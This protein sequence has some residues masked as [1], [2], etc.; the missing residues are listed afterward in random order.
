MNEVTP[1]THPDWIWP[2][3]DSHI[4]LAAG[5]QGELGS[6]DVLKTFVEP[7]GSFSPGFG[8]YGVSLW[9]WL[10]AERL[11]VAP[12]LLPR[13]EIRDR[14][15]GGMLP[16]VRSRWRAGE[17]EVDLRLATDSLGS[18]HQLIDT[19][20]A[21]ITNRGQQP[22][23]AKVLLVVRSLGPAGGPVRD[24]AVD[25]D[26][27]GLLVNG[28]L[29]VMGNQAPDDAGCC[30]LAQD[31]RDV[32]VML[33]GGAMPNRVAAHDD[34][35][36]ASAAL[37][38]SI[39]LEPGGVWEGGW[40]CPVWPA[41]AEPPA[42]LSARCQWPAAARIE[43]LADAW[44]DCVA[45]VW[46][47]C[48]DVR[49]SE[50][51]C[52]AVSHTLM[53]WADDEA[54]I[55]S[56][57]Y[58]FFW[59]RD[60]V[61]L[62]NLLD[63]A[64]HHEL[65]RRALDALVDDP[66]AGGFG[67]EADGPAQLLWVIGEHY[68]FTRDA[69]W[70]RSVYPRVRERAE[71]LRAM[72]STTEPMHGPLRRVLP[73]TRRSPEGTLL[74]E[75]A[76]H[77]LIWGR[78]DWHRPIFWVNAWARIGLKHAAFLASEL[79]CVDDA[80]LWAAEVQALARALASPAASFGGNERDF[81]CAIWPCDARHADDLATREEFERRWNTLR[82]G[83][84]RVYHGEP[85]W[86]YFEAAEAHN[87]LRLGH[88]DRALLVLEQFLRTQD[89]PG[90]YGWAEGDDTGDPTGDWKDIRG[91]WP[92]RRRDLRRGSAIMPHGWISAELALL[93][94]DLLV[95][96]DDGQLVIGAGVRPEWIDPASGLAAEGA[97]LGITEI[98]RAHV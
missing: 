15:L 80:A 78:M 69:D 10:E 82:L 88:A 17:A 31:G 21:R 92:A 44:R 1:Q 71:L 74:C 27:H 50:L 43:G 67:P 6:P 94:R 34:A 25:P 75:P 55:A 72:R 87:L 14:L 35:G 77:G 28:R 59:T 41:W 60:G 32:S 68:L 42:A 38:Y 7:G 48:P 98:G 56:V 83:R 47:Q 5:A 23:S 58:P 61:Y 86:R 54:R 2:R 16:I 93:V 53:A 22:L 26:V 18:A 91:W 9:L 66:W 45:A 89:A 64:G 57:C 40:D 63:K 29:A 8:S 97:W 95:W 3:A 12:E 84:D 13:P 49:L 36:W 30:S 51:F 46:P 62:L 4:V 81:A 65:V 96:E 79:D 90:L 70:L 37:A 76:R 39:E 33:R 11:L 24:V 73:R 85:R 19:L 52:A 20:A